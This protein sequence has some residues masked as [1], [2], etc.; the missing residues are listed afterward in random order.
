MAKELY[1]QNINVKDQMP[2]LVKGPVKHMQLVKY[3]GASGDFNPL[4]VDPEV[5]KAVGIGGQIAHGMLVMGFV[6]QA[7]AGW[8]PKKYLRKF[9]VRFVGMTRLNETVTVTG[10]VTDKKQERGNNIIRGEV[11]ARDQKEE[12]LIAGSFE[13]HLPEK[14]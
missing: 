6:G 2:V 12:L 1:F 7:L 5:G 9:N 8:I 10:K 4:H 13:A 11:F 3:A 14:K